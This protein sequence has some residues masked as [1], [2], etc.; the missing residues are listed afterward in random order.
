MPDRRIVLAEVEL[1]SFGLPTVEPQIPAKVYAARLEAL[2]QRYRARGYD[3]FVVYGDREHFANVAYL[4]GY[5]PR[6]E[7]TLLIITD[8]G[9]P[10]LLVGNEG[11]GYSA[12][13]PV[14]LRRVLYQTFSLISQPRHTSPPLRTLLAAAG[15]KGGMKIGTAGWKYFTPQET[16]TPA[17]WL[18]IPAFIVETLRTLGCV[19]ENGTDLFMHPTEGLRA[20]NEVDQLA[21]FEFAATYA[22]QGVRNLLF[23]LQPGLTEYECARLMQMNGLPISLYPVVLSGERTAL[24]PG[25]PSSRKIAVGEPMLAALGYWGSNTARAGFLVESEAQL[26]LAIRDYVGRLAVPYFR[27]AVAWYERIGIGVRGGELY[28][29]VHEYVGAPFFGVSLNPGHLIHLDEWVSSPIYKGS[30]ERLCSGMALQVDIIP[31]TGTPYFSS[32]VEDGIALAAE[33]LRAEFARKYPEAWARIQ[34]RR[35]FMENVLGIRIKPEVLPFSNLPAYLPPF[36]LAPR[37]VLRVAL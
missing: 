33:N 25:G 16:D 7:E 26:P 27:A 29:A 22:S 21:V 13:S 32:N 14:P 18:E 10:S 11:M 31:A 8:E 3:A 15:I 9:V 36:W 12:I 35:Q 37:Q 28:D 34:A 17:S 20:V 6:F 23:N 30:P 24:A 4:T 1:P 2:R 19:V 5:D